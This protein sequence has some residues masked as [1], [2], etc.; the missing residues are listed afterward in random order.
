MDRREFLQSIAGAAAFAAIPGIVKASLAEVDAYTVTLP[1]GE[2]FPVG[3]VFTFMTDPTLE[4]MQVGEVTRFQHKYNDW[5][6][7]ESMPYTV[8]DGNIELDPS[9]CGHY[10]ASRK[11]LYFG[12]PF[13]T[14]W[15]NTGRKLERYG[16]A[17]VMKAKD[18]MW[19]VYGAGLV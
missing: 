9:M 14:T 6:Y 4:V 16:V 13:Q 5:S 8:T 11:P 10:I 17:H 12:E 19:L 1:V 3:T 2:D 15:D 18:K 7:M